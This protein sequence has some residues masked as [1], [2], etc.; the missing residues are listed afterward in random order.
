MLSEVGLERGSAGDG[1]VKES[2]EPGVTKYSSQRSLSARFSRESVV[3]L[4]PVSQ[5][6]ACI[7][8]QPNPSSR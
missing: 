1:P 3:H 5:E 4:L 6:H 8:K 7:V 2:D